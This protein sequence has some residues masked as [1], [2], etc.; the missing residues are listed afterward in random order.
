[1]D[2]QFLDVVIWMGN[3]ILPSVLIVV[4]INVGSAVLYWL[5]E[6]VKSVGVPK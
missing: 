2:I 6:D 3:I 4:G 1:M 5:V